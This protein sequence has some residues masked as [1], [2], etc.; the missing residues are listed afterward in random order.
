[1]QRLRGQGGGR[2]NVTHHATAEAKATTC[3][4]ALDIT[5]PDGLALTEDPARVTC[6][7]CRAAV[8]PVFADMLFR[9][10]RRADAKRERRALGRA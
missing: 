7:H 6:H 9:A 10:E 8:D 5:A 4:I 3:G 1:V 2:L